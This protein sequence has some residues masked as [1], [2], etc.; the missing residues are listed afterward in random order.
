[1]DQLATRPGEP[2]TYLLGAERLGVEGDRGPA[3]GYHQPRGDRVQAL[4][5]RPH[6]AGLGC[7]HRT[8][9]RARS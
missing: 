4:G 5:D 9:S 6:R 2:L 3:I 8:S 7:G 1:M